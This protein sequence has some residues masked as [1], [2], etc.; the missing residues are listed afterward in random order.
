MLSMAGAFIQPSTRSA[1]AAPIRRFATFCGDLGLSAT[2]PCPKIAALFLSE[3][4]A[5]AAERGIGPQSVEQASAALTAH[6]KQMG[7]SSPCTDDPLCSMLRKAAKNMLH[8]EKRVR[9]PILAA[10]LLAAVQCHLVPGCTLLDR[11]VL[12]VMVLSFFGFLRFSEAE[13]ILVHHQFLVV[14]D[15][16]IQ[17]YIWKSKTDAHA[18]G[19]RKDIPATGGPACPVRLLRELLAA[20]EYK[21]IPAVQQSA[22]G[23]LFETEELGPLL[24]AVAPSATC[25]L[26]VTA[27]RGTINPALRSVDYLAAVHRL[28]RT[29]G[30]TKS[31][32]THSLRS[33]GATEALNAG[34]PARLVLRHG[35]WHD[36]AVFEEAYAKDAERI[37]SAPLAAGRGIL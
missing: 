26:Q 13:K 12:T 29:A 1:Y 22:G 14:R 10:D 17:L 19:C 6:F 21:T 35:N 23:E 25:L 36:A 18:V 7:H 33:G 2:T 34:V 15:E 28:M 27:P 8:A 30:I 4:I 9:E 32:G 31:I 11:M 16:G 24:R 5:R 37:A 3:E 20:G